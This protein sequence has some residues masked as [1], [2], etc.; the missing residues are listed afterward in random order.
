MLHEIAGA[1]AHFF[2]IKDLMMRSVRVCSRLFHHRLG[3]GIP[4]LLDPL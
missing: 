1:S 2:I 4:V 3:D